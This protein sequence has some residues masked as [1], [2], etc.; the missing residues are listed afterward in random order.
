MNLK[1]KIIELQKTSKINNKFLPN[2]NLQKHNFIPQL[3]YINKITKF[4]NKNKLMNLIKKININ[5][6]LVEPK[7]DGMLISIIYNEKNLLCIISKGNRH[8]GRDITKYFIET[9]IIPKN[10]DVEFLIEIRG[11]AVIS[12]NIFNQYYAKDFVDSRSL[13]SS[14]LHKKNID[15]FFINNLE[16]YIHDTGIINK[17]KFKNQI[18]I[19][20]FLLRNNF[21]VI[22]H[23]LININEISNILDD[24]QN[25]LYKCDGII[26]KVNNICDQISLLNNSKISKNIIAFKYN[27]IFQSY[28]NKISFIISKDGNII[29]IL[30]ID[31]VYCDEKKCS[32]I[33]L[34]SYH[35]FQK[36][37]ITIGCKINIKYNTTFIYESINEHSKQYVWNEIINCFSCN[38]TL[39]IIGKKL[40]C[41][42]SNCKLKNIAMLFS[43]IKLKGIKSI[44][45][46]C[47][48]DL[49]NQEII[50]HPIDIFNT[51][52]YHQINEK[53]KYINGYKDK[54]IQNIIGGLKLI[55]QSYTLSDLIILLSIPSIGQ[56]TANKLEK[57]YIKNKIC[58]FDTSQME[59]LDFLNKIQKS[60]I[61]N[62]Y[63][64]NKELIEKFKSYIN[65]FI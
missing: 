5:E 55:R 29:P 21:K 43:Y 35:I 60:N 4:N 58:I 25:N 38:Y 45:I 6:I 42:N 20:K 63:K 51:K 62:F 64:N 1:I 48:Q 19:Y 31:P 3:T 15:L 17:D 9:N 26:F 34:Y 11:E 44:G 49:F 8:S 54:K 41:N 18:D 40:I 23:K 52:I 27:Q 39:E 16:I 10:I 47:I 14:K 50:M 36:D 32:K 59:K 33:S 13:V 7:M 2:L 65:E 56:E 46:S 53:F 30:H 12:E 28:V 24:Y 37:K 22:N 61:F 57:E